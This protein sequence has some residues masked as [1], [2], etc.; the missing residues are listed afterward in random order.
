MEINTKMFDG[1]ADKF[2]DKDEPFKI[3]A[4]AFGGD[5]EQLSI[6]K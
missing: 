3:I 6:V 2:V 5:K 4:S 1:Y